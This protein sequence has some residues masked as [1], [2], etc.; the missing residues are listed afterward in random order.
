MLGATQTRTMHLLF[1]DMDAKEMEREAEKLSG[2]IAA[3]APQSGISSFVNRLMPDGLTPA[4]MVLSTLKGA[5]ELVDDVFGDPPARSASGADIERWV[6]AEEKLEDQSDPLTLEGM[7][8]RLPGLSRHGTGLSFFLPG[9]AVRMADLPLPVHTPQSMGTSARQ[10][11]HLEAQLSLV[12][13]GKLEEARHYRAGLAVGRSA[14]EQANLLRDE[15]AGAAR[16]K[17]DTVG[18]AVMELAE[19]A[20]AY[21][22]AMEAALGL[23]ERLQ[24]AQDARLELIALIKQAKS[25]LSDPPDSLE[26]AQ[27]EIEE[28]AKKA[29]KIGEAAGR[30]TKIILP[31]E[32]ATNVIEQIRTATAK[33]KADQT[34]AQRAQEK[35]AE[36]AQA[37][38]LECEAGEEKL[39]ELDEK[40]AEVDACEVNAEKA[41]EKIEGELA[42][43]GTE[44]EQKENDMRGWAQG[45]AAVV[46]RNNQLADKVLDGTE[47]A[48]VEA[49]TPAQ[50]A[51]VGQAK[52]AVWRTLAW[53]GSVEKDGRLQHSE[54]LS[55]DRQRDNLGSLIAHERRDLSR[56][57]AALDNL[58]PC[59]YAEV[60]PAAFD[61]V[62]RVRRRLEAFGPAPEGLPGRH[63]EDP[64]SGGGPSGAGA[65]AL[66]EV[67]GPASVFFDH[68]QPKGPG[69]A[70][71]RLTQGF[72]DI[73]AYLQKAEG[74]KVTLTAH[75]S[76]PGSSRYNRSLARRRAAVVRQLIERN[77]KAHAVTSIET[78]P[79]G[80]G[81]KSDPSTAEGAKVE[82]RRKG[83]EY[84]DAHW[85]RVDV[86]VRGPDTET[87]ESE[88]LSG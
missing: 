44:L 73:G 5:G 59:D 70:E 32:F 58:N 40:E 57:A 82:A 71:P 62:S 52:Q 74:A 51:S 33:N 27:E 26:D 13:E 29:A 56:H 78:N 41:A 68:D 9:E 64:G 55:R 18:E 25:N 83:G 17:V 39:G 53:L 30:A 19:A 7:K 77:A 31:D 34:A 46:T 38:E 75:A 54:G 72:H 81:D 86:A 12:R 65:G 49:L 48:E 22:S 2:E 8:A 20:Q 84:D 16:D 4:D 79:I 24:A 45:H 66:P 15:A 35:A 6:A 87:D 76:V 69:S 37:A 85:R 42:A 28:A 88:S 63:G 50:E 11:T 67:P 1:G 80:D 21:A 60:V 23:Q 43:A 47:M 10:V 3:I 61:T 36:A 14:Q